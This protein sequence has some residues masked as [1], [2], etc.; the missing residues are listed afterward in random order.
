MY[1]CSGGG[2]RRPSGVCQFSTMQHSAR[3][4]AHSVPLSI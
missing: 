4:V 3:S 2:M 1:G